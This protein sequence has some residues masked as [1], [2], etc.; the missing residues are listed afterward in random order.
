MRRATFH[1]GDEGSGRIDSIPT[2]MEAS[3]SVS[4][5]GGPSKKAVKKANLYAWLS[6]QTLPEV[7]K[8]KSKNQNQND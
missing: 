8:S 7:K 4:T 6:L 5:L 2:I 3:E 1:Y